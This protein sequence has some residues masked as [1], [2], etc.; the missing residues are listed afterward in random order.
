MPRPSEQVERVFQQALSLS[1]DERA[2]LV[3]ELVATLPEPTDQDDGDL[4]PQQRAELQQRFD[5]LG[6]GV[7]VV[8]PWTQARLQIEG[9]LRAVREPRGR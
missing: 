7:T 6:R 8:V 1:D 2:W 9:R 5:D 4:S 3:A